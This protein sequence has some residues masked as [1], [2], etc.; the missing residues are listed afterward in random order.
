MQERWKRIENAGGSGNSYD[1]N[2]SNHSAVKI[3]IG[4]RCLGRDWN[5][6]DDGNGGARARTAEGA[7]GSVPWAGVYGG[8][9][10]EDE[11][12]AGVAGRV[13]KPGGGRNIEEREDW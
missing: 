13:S 4:E 2:R 7:H 10:T 3:R 8:L 11:A 5:R 1:E 12:G 6:R 9:A